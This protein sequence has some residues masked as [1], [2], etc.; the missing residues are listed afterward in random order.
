M[1][2]ILY[3]ETGLSVPEI[4]VFHG[5]G[6]RPRGKII[7]AKACFS[8]CRKKGDIL[9]LMLNWVTG[10]NELRVRDSEKFPKCAGRQNDFDERNNHG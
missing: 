3:S 8:E 6:V 2:Q 9:I 1:Q 4:A 7:V 10:E 5:Q